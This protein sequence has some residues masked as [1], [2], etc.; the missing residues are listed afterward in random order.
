MPD[1]T[2][3]YVANAFDD[4]VS[5]LAPLTQAVPS[6]RLPALVGEL[7]GGVANDGDGWLV[8]GDHFYKIPPRPVTAVAA[9]ARTAAPCLGRPI[10]NPKLGEQLRDS[11]ARAQRPDS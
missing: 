5:V 9:I 7:L 3:V 2:R 6:S 8:I 11:L 1:G 4:T 10:D